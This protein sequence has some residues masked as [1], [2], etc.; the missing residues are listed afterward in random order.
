MKN[1]VFVLLLHRK[2]G[3]SPDHE[4]GLWELA[5]AGRGVCLTTFGVQKTPRK[6]GTSKK[7]LQAKKTHSLRTSIHQTGTEIHTRGGG[8]LMDQ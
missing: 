7:N 4:K 1:F 5:G 6:G 2:T 3:F 8:A